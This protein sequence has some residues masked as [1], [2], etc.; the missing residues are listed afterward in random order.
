MGGRAVVSYLIFSCARPHLEGTFHIWPQKIE[1]QG[2]RD[3]NADCTLEKMPQECVNQISANLS[4]D[5]G[6]SKPPAPRAL[7]EPPNAGCEES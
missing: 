1:E 7:L 3:C 2:A 6:D 4:R 5:D